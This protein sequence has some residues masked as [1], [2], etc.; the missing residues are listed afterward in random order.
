MTPWHDCA[1]SHSRP[2]GAVVAGST[3]R[4]THRPR[5]LAPTRS[6]RDTSCL[7]PID[8]VP[9]GRPAAIIVPVW[10][11]HAA[12][13]PIYWNLAWPVRLPLPIIPGI[14]DRD[15]SLRWI[16]AKA[17]SGTIWKRLAG[18]R[19]LYKD[20]AYHHE[21][22]YR[23]AIPGDSPDIRLYGV[24][25]ETYEEGG[26]IVEVRHYC[27]IADL[28]LRKLL[29]SNSKLILGPSVNDRYSVRLY[30]EDLRSQ[31]HTNDPSLYLF[32]IQ[33]SQ[34]RYRGR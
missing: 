9:H 15:V 31:A 26:S 2:D 5:Q 17:I 1:P 12:L 34:I 16:R 23:V 27:E 3:H 18:V 14:N 13:I 20:E 6:A 24:R 7:P 25:F 30:F 32:P 4:A 8:P 19:Y 21:Q 11:P 33:E 29:V 28:D 22:E 10:L